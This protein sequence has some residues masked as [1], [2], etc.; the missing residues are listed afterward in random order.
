V[1]SIGINLLAIY[2]NRFLTLLPTRFRFQD[3]LALAAMVDRPRL[4]FV[5]WTDRAPFLLREK[6][7]QKGPAKILKVRR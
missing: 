3:K 6:G 1:D 7:Q 2:T 5:R 4:N